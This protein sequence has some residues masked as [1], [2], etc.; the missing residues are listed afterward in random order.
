MADDRGLDPATFGSSG[1]SFSP[2]YTGYTNTQGEANTVLT[3]SP[4]VATWIKAWIRD[5]NNLEARD[6]IE[7]TYVPP[8]PPP[9]HG[10][11]L[12]SQA[13]HNGSARGPLGSDGDAT[14]AYATPAYKSLDI[15]RGVTLV[16]SSARALPRGFVQLEASD[17]SIDDPPQ[18]SLRLIRK[19]NG[20]AATLLSGGTE[21][22]YQAGNG[23]FRL[24][25]AFAADTMATGAYDYTARV[26]N[27][28]STDSI[29]DSVTVRVLI[30][31]EQ[32]SPFGWGWSLAGLQQLHFGR[33]DSSVVVT[34]GDGS[35]SFFANPGC[36]PSATC[37]YSRPAGD[38]TELKYDATLGKFT[39]RAIDG[40]VSTF[41]GSGP[42]RGRLEKVADRYGNT[43][44]FTYVSG[45]LERINDP[46]GK[47]I[48]LE[49]GVQGIYGA[50]GKLAKIRDPGGRESKFAYDASGHH[51]IK[52]VDPDGVAAVEAVYDA[53]HRVVTRWGRMR[54][55]TDVVY[56]GHSTVDSVK[57]PRVTTSDAGPVRPLTLMRSI[58]RAALPVS[59]K[60]SSSV[61]A[62]AVRPESV[63]VRVTSPR[64]AVTKSW[65]HALGGPL[66][67]I[68]R[69]PTGAEHVTTWVRNADGL[70]TQVTSP[71]NAITTYKWTGALLDSTMDYSTAI[72]TR[73]EYE[74]TYAQVKKVFVNGDL[75]L[76]NFYGTLGQLDSVKVDT[77][78]S[79]FTYDPRGRLLTAKD[80]DGHEQ[81]TAYLATGFKNTD[82]VAVVRN[83]VERKTTFAYDTF[84]RDTSATDHTGRVFKTAFDSLNRVRSTSAPDTMT[85]TYA[86]ED[87]VRRYTV[88]DA[89][90]QAYRD[91]LNALGWVMK[92]TD[93]RGNSD[94]FEY[95]RHGN[96]TRHT[97]R[98]NAVV[99]FEYD[100]LDRVKK[101]VAEAIDGAAQDS[102]E[103]FYDPQKEWVAVVNGESV[104]TLRFLSDGRAYEGSVAAARS[105][106]TLCGG[107]TMTM[108]SRTSRVSPSPSS[109][110]T[111]TASRSG[112]R[113]RTR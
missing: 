84:G 72:A 110:A 35:I 5:I 24:G 96:V 23:A 81:R 74:P 99:R 104:D 30:V 36:T 94:S 6:S 12:L 70:P 78:V 44:T 73:Y 80:P 15:A 57:A 58:T 107:A 27:R 112:S 87:A 46:A 92:R 71:T 93:P 59:G 39:R 17:N 83:G 85:I 3:L 42:D 101:R 63:Y 56:D 13:P 34:G 47:E 67:V 20:Q 52:V 55:T 1:A 66:K 18:M 65:L 75:R 50:P 103:F 48:V 100:S 113:P 9:T 14:L 29:A 51:L 38:F 2:A 102:A 19:T 97:S 69:D 37:T 22:F 111:R 33:P 40:T 95:D 88:T 77:S 105:A 45:R 43:M 25:A 62:D 91:S 8:P 60:G 90:N 68:E 64:G 54:D 61:P 32:A 98:R 76:T 89:K 79:R 21:V 7:L 86:Y 11:P 109:R 106:A 108:R 41:F 82:W 26:T 10:P 28:W 49:Y 16:Y 53:S 4:N 31:N